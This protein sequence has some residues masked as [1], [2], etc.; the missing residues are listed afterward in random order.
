VLILRVVRLGRARGWSEIG[1]PVH[2]LTNSRLTAPAY[3]V[4][5]VTDLRQP[6][7]FVVSNMRTGSNTAL[8]FLEWIVSLFESGVVQ[9]GDYLIMDNASIHSAEQVADALDVL[10]TAFRARLVFLPTYS[11]ELNPCEMVFGQVK[12]HLRHWRQDQP[13]WF[14]IVQGFARVSLENVRNYYDHCL[15]RFDQ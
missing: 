6:N 14:E 10:F 2:V 4:T 9:A 5:L 15:F 3:S 1:R 7:G 12:R 13:F 8:D 11:P